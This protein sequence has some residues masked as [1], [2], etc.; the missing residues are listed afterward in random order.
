M[1]HIE[2]TVIYITSYIDIDIIMK[3]IFITIAIDYCLHLSF[4]WHRKR[5]M[6]ARHFAFERISY[7]LF[8]L[9][10]LEAQKRR[11]WSVN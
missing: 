3:S 8:S 5:S 1:S 7:I 11:S 4:Y 10:I 6:I 9:R 2:R